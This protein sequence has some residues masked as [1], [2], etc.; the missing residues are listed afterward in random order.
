MVPTGHN[1]HPTPI[2]LAFILSCAPPVVPGQPSSRTL[3]T[4]SDGFIA[5]SFPCPPGHEEDPDLARANGLYKAYVIR[6]SQSSRPVSTVSVAFYKFPPGTSETLEEY[7]AWDIAEYRKRFPGGTATRAPLPESSTNKFKRLGIE[8]DSYLFEYRKANPQGGRTFADSLAL[9][10]RTPSGV[11]TVSWSTLSEVIQS[12]STIFTTFV[13]GIEVASV[14]DVKNGQ[15]SVPTLVSGLVKPPGL[16]EKVVPKYPEDARRARLMGKV[17][18]KA[19]IDESGNVAHVEV[20]EGLS[21]S[22]DRAALKAVK[23]WRYRPATLD[24]K[25]VRVYFTVVVNFNLPQKGDSSDPAH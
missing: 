5:F 18:L 22:L 14:M 6:K 15:G 4:V 24:G 2:L 19:I 12:Q 17:V 25:E 20:V 1:L 23:K 21:E 7:V 8:F 11:W 10:L 13:D 9:H 16:I 3:D